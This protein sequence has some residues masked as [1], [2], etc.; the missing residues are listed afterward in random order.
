MLTSFGIYIG[1][2]R[3]EQIWFSYKS[4][5]MYSIDYRNAWPFMC[6]I[7]VNISDGRSNLHVS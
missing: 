6:A 7:R 3:R 2:E 4:S 5:P 1:T